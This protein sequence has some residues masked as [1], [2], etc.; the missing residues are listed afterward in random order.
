MNDCPWSMAWAMPKD[1]HFQ[2]GRRGQIGEGDRGRKLFPTPNDQRDRH[3]SSDEGHDHRPALEGLL[4]RQD[5]LRVSTHR[6]PH[7]RP[8]HVGGS[9]HR[10]KRRSRRRRLQECRRRLLDR[11]AGMR[12]P[13][14][15]LCNQRRMLEVLHCALENRVE[16]RSRLQFG[17]H[18]RPLAQDFRQH[19]R[20][21]ELAAARSTRREMPMKR[22]VPPS[23]LVG[24]RLSTGWR[25]NGR[26]ARQT[27]RAAIHPTS[28]EGL[29]AAPP[30][31]SWGNRVRTTCSRARWAR[32]RRDF[33][34][35]NDNPSVAARSSY[36]M[37][38]K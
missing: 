32:A 9:R 26:K 31:S 33:T 36:D 1:G 13:T 10:R 34:V 4:F 38:S 11:S 5:R 20:S 15:K 28:S 6:A 25:S 37:S 27:G 29:E 21:L 8:C 14:S 18:L 24:E 30:R 7:L 19:P 23:Q 2:R 3:G 17:R 35:P 12:N 22:F 16:Q